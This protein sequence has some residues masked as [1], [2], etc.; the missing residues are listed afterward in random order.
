MKMTPFTEDDYFCYG[1][2]DATDMGKPALISEDGSI[3]VDLNGI[4]VHTDKDEDGNFQKFYNVEVPYDLAVVMAKAM[5][6]DDVKNF[7]CGYGE[8]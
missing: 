8:L 5:Q 4:E 1:V 3:V 6:E 7:T 2:E